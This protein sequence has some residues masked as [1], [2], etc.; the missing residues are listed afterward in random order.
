MSPNAPEIWYYFIPFIIMGTG[1]SADAFV[2]KTFKVGSAERGNL[3]FLIGVF[4][5]LAS[6]GELV[7]FYLEGITFLS[8]TLTV[9]LVFYGLVPLLSIALGTAS[10][11]VL[12]HR[13]K[14]AGGADF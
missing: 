3:K 12:D 8:Y 14:K 7:V 10:Y 11:I 5:S 13:F 2:H 1:L 6:V 4:L 9:F